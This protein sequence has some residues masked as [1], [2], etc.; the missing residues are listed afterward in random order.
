MK[1]IIIVTTRDYFDI[2]SEVQEV[3]ENELTSLLLDLSAPL[4]REHLEELRESGCSGAEEQILHN[5]YRLWLFLAESSDVIAEK[6]QSWFQSESSTFPLKRVDLDNYS[7][8]LAPC[9]PTYIPEDRNIRQ[10]YLAALIK[11]CVNDSN[12]AIDSSHLYV[13]CHDKDIFDPKTNTDR[14]PDPSDILGE[15]E[16]H[17][18]IQSDIV[19]LSNM[20]C[21]MHS[22]SDS[23]LYKSFIKALP[24]VSSAICEDAVSA[25]TYYAKYDK[26]VA[27]LSREQEEFYNNL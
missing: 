26:A 12:S 15:T 21:F 11:L 25:I 7:V 6:L 9:L 4:D 17:K 5:K 18:L 14:N 1:S 24:K 23:L 8:Y 20:Y 10:N 2:T 16:L 27:G 19:K 3:C 13:L 22:T